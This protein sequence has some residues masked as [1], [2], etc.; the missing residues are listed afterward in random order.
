MQEPEKYVN[1][2]CN[3]NTKYGNYSDIV[4]RDI[5]KGKEI[6][7]NYS[8]IDSINDIE[9]YNCRSINCISNFK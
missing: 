4:I 2:S 7:G 9:K 8:D 6:T 5:K 3:P 1:H